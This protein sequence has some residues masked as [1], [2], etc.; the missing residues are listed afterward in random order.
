MDKSRAIILMG[1]S[2]CGKSTVGNQLSQTTGWR[3]FDGDD[4]HSPENIAKMSSGRSLTDQDR[5]PWLREIQG[6]IDRHL[7]RGESLIVACSALKQKYREILE[8]GRRE[9]VSFVYLKGD[10][11]LIY[12]RL[13]AR[14]EHFMRPDLLRSQFEIIEEPNQVLV[15][16]ISD[17]VGTIVDGIIDALGLPRVSLSRISK[18]LT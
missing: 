16:D 7:R 4:L 11:D 13:S 1:V 8:N 17:P 15:I 6:L 2:G 14:S 3:F 12:Q 18:P 5:L 9:Q 10:F